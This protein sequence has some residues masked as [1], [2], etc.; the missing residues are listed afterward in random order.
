MALKKWATIAHRHRYKVSLLA[1]VITFSGVTLLLDAP[2]G[3]I[4]DWLG[5]PLIVLG[6]LLITWGV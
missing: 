3:A 4:L 5:V 2:K 1:L 6:G